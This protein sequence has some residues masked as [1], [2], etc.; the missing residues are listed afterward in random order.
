ML[1]SALRRVRR[2][3]RAPA[4]K[5]RL[6]ESLVDVDPEFWPLYEQ[7][8][9]A[10]LTSAE[11]LYALYKS[12]EYIV[13]GEVPG[14][15]V[16]CGVWHGGSF[17]M[18]ALALRQFGDV[19]RHLFGFDTFDYVPEP[20]ERDIRQDTGQSAAEFLQAYPRDHWADAFEAARANIASTRYP[21]ELVT[22]CKGRVEET[23]PGSAPEQI[24]LLRLDTDWYESTRHEL[25]HLYPRLAAGGVLIIDDYG[26]WRGAR[27]ATDEYFRDRRDKVLLNRVDRT[28]RIG[29]KIA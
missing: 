14:D 2:I 8:K 4:R 15:L 1:R 16:E 12:I 17:M 20:G 29:V 21:S 19:R 24:A 9:P 13:R 3:V 11:Q 18:M 27:E 7:C 23:V 25:V 28:G 10:T 26:F 5:R 6:L 22:L